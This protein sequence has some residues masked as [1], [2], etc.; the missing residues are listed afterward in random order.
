M[1]GLER[2]TTVRLA[3]IL[4]Q[5]G[6]I[7]TDMIT[8]SLYEQDQTGLLF[9]EILI[10]SGEVAEWD[11]AKTVVRHF[12]LPFIMSANLDV[13]PAAVKTLP[14][15]FLFQHRLLPFDINGNVLSISMPIL[16]PYKVLNEAQ[17]LSELIIFPVVGLASDNAKL[18]HQLFP[19]HPKE[20]RRTEAKGLIE[21]APG[22]EDGSSWENI[23]DM[24]D[25]QVLKDLG[26]S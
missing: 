5:S 15:D 9:V 11:I 14:E 26:G 24:G 19:D 25:E 16:V 23:F 18:L 10:E 1:K 12:Q 17:T 3:E 2:I 6:G 13:E 4:S 20:E 22:T 8:N 7:P 21:K